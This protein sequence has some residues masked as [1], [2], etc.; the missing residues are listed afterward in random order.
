MKYLNLTSALVL[1]GAAIFHAVTPSE[2]HVFLA[3]TA[4]IASIAAG[5]CAFLQMK[6]SVK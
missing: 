1:G 2:Q 3:V 4:G 6:R 5:V